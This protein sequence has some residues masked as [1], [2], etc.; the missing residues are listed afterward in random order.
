MKGGTAHQVI[1]LVT[2]KTLYNRHRTFNFG[3]DKFIK[4]SNLHF[5][6][7]NYEDKG[8]RDKDCDV[9]LKK[10]HQNISPSSEADISVLSLEN[11]DTETFVKEGYSLYSWDASTQCF[12]SEDRS[13]ISPISSS[14]GELSVNGFKYLPQLLYLRQNS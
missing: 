4:V 14:T 2:L 7:A 5:F 9:F 3:T 1:T 11:N 13:P 10:F 6:L 8:I 12:P